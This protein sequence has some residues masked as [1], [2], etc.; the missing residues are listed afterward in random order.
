MQGFL[1]NPNIGV[2]TDG[3]LGIKMISHP[4]YDHGKWSFT[5][6]FKSE[7][8]CY[9]GDH[10]NPGRITLQYDICIY[11]VDMH[12]HMIHSPHDSQP[13]TK[14]DIC[15]VIVHV[16]IM[17]ED[18]QFGHVSWKHQLDH[19]QVSAIC[20]LKSWNAKTKNVHYRKREPSPKGVISN[21]YIYI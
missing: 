12:S 1:S 15:H 13:N 3:G 21:G 4:G 17:F 5:G 20:C 14:P 2:R 6:I 10:W 7:L 8:W 9:P 19:F 18:L 16:V 11:S